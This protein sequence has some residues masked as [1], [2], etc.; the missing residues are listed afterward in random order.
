MSHVPCV[1]YIVSAYMVWYI[2]SAYRSQQRSSVYQRAMSPGLSCTE[3]ISPER[4]V[5][6]KFRVETIHAEALANA[7]DAPCV[8]SSCQ[9]LLVVRCS[10]CAQ[11]PSPCALQQMR[12][13]T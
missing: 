13:I 11:R 10:A 1:W 8:L 6:L 2:V 3:T 7:S 5:T 12:G 4:A 9:S